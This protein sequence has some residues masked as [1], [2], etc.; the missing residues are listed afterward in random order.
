MES[1]SS[2]ASVEMIIR[3]TPVFSQREASSTDRIPP[4][5]SIS[6]PVFFIRSMISPAFFEGLPNAPSRL[7]IW[8]ASAPWSSQRVAQVSGSPYAVALSRFPWTSWTQRPPRISTAGKILMLSADHPLDCHDKDIFCTRT[9]QGVD[10][11]VNPF[12]VYH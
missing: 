5:S 7:T 4:P 12:F 6:T 8:R 2:V 9:L 11:G 10:K 3:E 1:G